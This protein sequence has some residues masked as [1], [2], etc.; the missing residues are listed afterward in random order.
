M[1]HKFLE[2]EVV[3]VEN[4]RRKVVNEEV[5]RMGGIHHRDMGNMD[6]RMDLLHNKVC[7]C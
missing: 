2:S 5:V 7:V 1:G 6:I 4:H 3:A